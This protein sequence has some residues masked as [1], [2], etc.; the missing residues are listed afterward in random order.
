MGGGEALGFG[1]AD[2]LPFTGIST[3]PLA[4]A[5]LVA[6]VVGSVMTRVGRKQP[7]PATLY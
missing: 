6:A 7:A 4:L 5:G 2:V 3:V 1:G